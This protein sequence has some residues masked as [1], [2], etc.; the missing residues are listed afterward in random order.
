MTPGGTCPGQRRRACSGPSTP[1]SLLLSGAT[2]TNNAA[3]A[4][5]YV[6]WGVF[7]QSQRLNSAGALA[8]GWSALLE[9]LF[10]SFNFR[11][12]TPVI[13]ISFFAISIPCCTG[14]A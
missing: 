12:K 2:T 3:M 4:G 7:L 6:V 9:M 1:P 13:S 14:F 8:I 11:C 5:F 10:L